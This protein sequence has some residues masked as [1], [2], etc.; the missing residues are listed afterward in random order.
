MNQ[1]GKLASSGRIILGDN[2]DVL[3]TLPA[4]SFDLIY[5]DPPFNT[6]QMRRHTR[7]RV[8]R[9]EGGDRVGFGGQRY[10]TTT[11]LTRLSYANGF[12]DFLAFLEP[13][14]HEARRLL[15]PTGSFF[16]HIDY[17]GEAAA[18]LGRD[19]VLV[20]ENLEAIRV[21]RDRL[22]F[23]DPE[24]VDGSGVTLEFPEEGP[25]DPP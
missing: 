3:P 10:R 15:R 5:I 1:Q 2:L 25:G 21:M 19:F 6:Q 24:L 8:E 22:A 13:R 23:A 14:L 18:R 16:L 20:D 17:R 12:D 4:A 7:V 9:D 11:A